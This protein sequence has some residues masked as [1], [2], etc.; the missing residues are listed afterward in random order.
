M[1][2]RY[3]QVGYLPYRTSV[4]MGDYLM[5][6]LGYFRDVCYDLKR[7]LDPNNILSPGKS[8]IDLTEK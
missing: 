4:S 6:K 2:D 3:C 1:Y 5:K 8:G 7:L